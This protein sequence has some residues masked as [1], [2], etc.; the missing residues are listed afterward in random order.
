VAQ[1]A[2]PEYD[3][4]ALTQSAALADYFEAVAAEAG[5]A[6]A[7]SNWVMGELLRTMNDRGQRVEDLPL[8]ADRL[9][10]L[11]KVIDKGTISSTIAKD[12]F[13]KMYDSGRTAEEIVAAEGLAQIGDE[14]A[15]MA[16]IRDV[17]AAHRDAVAQ[18]RA[19]K[20]QTFGLLVGQVMKGSGGKAN[21]KLA[22]QLLKQELARD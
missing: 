7:A 8:G 19:G 15:L 2:I 9:A 21:P 18:Y 4:G 17:M 20:M 14:A 1:Y 6:K 10:G 13:A 12:V 11:I 22:N 16:I 3:A 5:N